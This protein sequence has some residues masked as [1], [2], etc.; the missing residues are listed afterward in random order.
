MGKLLTK[1]DIHEL[2]SNRFLDD[3]HTK[4]SLMPSPMLFKDMKKAALRIKRA[5]EN[6]ECITIVGDYDADGVIASVIVSQFFEATKIKHKLY[7]PNRFY[8]GYGLDASI[9]KKID[10]NVILTV[11]NGITAFDAGEICKLEKKDLIIT[12][13]HTVG[14]SLPFAYAIVNP[15]QKDCNFPCSE[16]C[17]AQVA[18]YLCAALK[19]VCGFDIDMSYWL[20]LLAIAIMADMMELRDLNR[21]M[22]KKGIQRLNSTSRASFLAVKD[23]FN[24]HKF[25]SDDISFLLA[26]LINSAGRMDDAMISF[27][28]L[29]AK[30]YN[31]A[32]FFLE[33]IVDLNNLRKKQESKLF[34]SSLCMVE[35]DEDIIVVWGEDWH[36]GVVG[37]VASRLSRRYKKPAIVF[38]VHEDKAKGSARSVGE[39]DILSL[40]SK[41]SELLLGFGGHK[42]AAGV[43]INSDKLPIF[44]ESLQKDCKN[45]DKSKFHAN[46]EVLGQIEPS[47]IDFELLNILKSFEPYGEKNPRPRFLIKDIKVKTNRL[48]GRE[49]NHLKLILNAK[50]RVLESLFFNFDKKVK[51]GDRIDILF[52]VSENNYRG[53]VTPQLLIQ[54]IL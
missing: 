10:T 33:K 14:D 32:M 37:I 53:L 29:N 54:E 38:S 25:R 20:D 21:V 7:I 19:E 46:I 51:S 43:A 18:W 22:V 31:D 45:I 30:N 26:P 9:V 6:Q 48:I 52:T 44:K 27:S 15:K 3:F 34:D 11:D 41:H 4:L 1:K 23:F 39:I 13:H 49:Q 17:G 16:I 36:E 2:L 50:N 8:D 42:G 24:K 5:W 12:D 47:E 40:I 35:D 28:F